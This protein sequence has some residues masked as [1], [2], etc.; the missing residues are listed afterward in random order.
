MV[1]QTCAWLSVNLAPFWRRSPNGRDFRVMPDVPTIT[2]FQRRG[3]LTLV[4]TCRGAEGEPALEICPQELN[5]SWGSYSLSAR[6]LNPVAEATASWRQ[7]GTKL[8]LSVRKAASGPHWR[9]LFEGGK[10][11]SVKPD[12]DR[13]VE[14]E[15][16]DD[17][18]EPAVPAGAAAS[19]PV[20]AEAAALAEAL[21]ALDLGSIDEESRL[22]QWR[23]LTMPQRM[24]TMALFWNS[25]SDPS[26]LASVHKLV[27]LLRG[28]GIDQQLAGI[29]ASIKGGAGVLRSLDTSVYKGERHA[30]GWVSAFAA[31]PDEQ[32]VALLAQLFK[33]LPTDEQR[34]VIG[35]LM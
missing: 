2:W 20:D 13:W 6:F 15:D 1:A 21:E 17:D 24:L 33:V 23:G 11:A 25:M 4:L 28:G 10:R 32:Q 12:W 26:R 9:A 16:D 8:E 35:S 30:K 5:L 27:E 31:K 22:E 19:A 14:E 7:S 3:E 29:D 34:L 18:P